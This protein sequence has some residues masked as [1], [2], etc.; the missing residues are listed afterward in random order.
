MSGYRLDS[1]AERAVLSIDNPPVN[2]L[3]TAILDSMARALRECDARALEIRA[4]GRVFSAGMDVREHMPADV[5]AMLAAARRFFEALWRFPGTVTAV[6]GGDAL[7]GAAEL[8][9]LCDF[10]LVHA[11]ASIAFPEIRVGAF[12]PLA[13][14]ILPAVLPWARAVDLILTGRRLTAAE[15]RDWGLVTA[16]WSSEDELATQLARIQGLSPT[17]QN[18]ARAAM[19]AGNDLF[20]RYTEAEALYLERLLRTDDALEGVLAFMARREPRWSGR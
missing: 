13:A 3:G 18:L 8:L 20:A 1:R 19:R 11:Q 7:G 16:T 10:V 5:P 6:V 12:P 14:V 4:V 17:V 9:L 2:V 15:A